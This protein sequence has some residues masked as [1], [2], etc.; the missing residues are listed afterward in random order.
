[1]EDNLMRYDPLNSKE[2]LHD[3]CQSQT[4]SGYDIKYSARARQTLRFRLGLVDLSGLAWVDL[5]GLGEPSQSREEIVDDLFHHDW[6]RRV[7][8]IRQVALWGNQI[9]L[10]SLLVLLKDEH[11][12]V[13]ETVIKTLGDLGDNIPFNALIACLEDEAWS[14][15]AAAIQ[16]L[17]NLR[18]HI[19]I[20]PLIKKLRDEDVSVRVAAIYALGNLG[21]LTP[22]EDIIL[23]LDDKDPLVQEAAKNVLSQ[24]SK[25]VGKERGYFLKQSLLNEAGAASLCVQ[26]DLREIIESLSIHDAIGEPIIE[27]KDQDF[28][29]NSAPSTHYYV[30]MSG[31][32]CR[33]K[34]S[35]LLAYTRSL[36]LSDYEHTEKMY[37]PSLI[38][39]EGYYKVFGASFL[40]S[41]PE[42]LNPPA[43]PWLIRSYI[44]S[45]RACLALSACHLDITPTGIE[46]AVENWLSTL[47][48]F[49]CQG[50]KYK[51][52]DTFF[53]SLLLS[54]I[55]SQP[56]CWN[57]YMFQ[58]IQKHGLSLSVHAI[59][60]Y[61][62]L[63]QHDIDQL[64]QY[65]FGSMI[66][67]DGI[68]DNHDQQCPHINGQGS[69]AL[70]DPTIT[71]LLASNLAPSINITIS[72]NMDKLR[73]LLEY[74][75]QRALSFGLSY[76]RDN[77][78]YTHLSD[79][80]FT[81]IHMASDIDIVFVSIEHHLPRR[82]SIDKTN[83]PTPPH[84]HTC[85]IGRNY[86][87][88]DQEGEIAKC[89][90]DIS[91][92]ITTVDAYNPLLA[93]REHRQKAQ[94]VAIDNKE[95]CAVAVS[96][97]TDAAAAVLYSHTDSQVEMIL[98]RLT[99]LFTKHFVP[100]L[101][102]WRHYVCSS[103]R[104]QSRY[105]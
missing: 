10:E 75:L 80:Q 98:N 25:K 50:S 9:P 19:P 79:L 62:T 41:L 28:S 89:Q 16:A 70:L 39:V 100:K 104:N 77:E 53:E 44:G 7:E 95:S 4:N 91:N 52:V 43:C 71:Q 18:E 1:M 64:K 99:T 96:G 12:I 38:D 82:S 81:D 66:C 76:Y 46:S 61:V 14:V 57:D 47:K 29:L 83:T 2:E 42:R 30:Y 40:Q 65:Q 49:K 102:V 101:C 56:T 86:L 54:C 6:V 63:L 11:I 5:P 3:M 72:Q 90:V 51:S 69:L 59:S 88:I 21:E 35:M 27:Q 22:I 94:I 17:G 92:T 73:S 78:C 68:G 58:Q 103:M 23:T 34:S 60:N 74:I 67:L 85:D 37:K 33:G 15:R 97:A 93:I 31:S 20:Y 24:L 55:Q 87:L 48:D 13:R 105:K 32:V 45:E 26:E 84:R 36:G 8:A